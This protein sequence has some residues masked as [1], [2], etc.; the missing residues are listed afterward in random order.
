M[1]ATPASCRIILISGA[2][3]IHECFKEVALSCCAP[4]ELTET[5]SAASASRALAPGGSDLVFIDDDLANEDIVQIVSAAR[6]SNNAPLTLLMT[7]SQ[8]TDAAFETD[9][10]TI[11]PAG[12]DDARRLIEGAIRLRRGMRVLVVD[13]SSTMRSIVRKVL[14][15]TRFP[16][17]IVEVN[18]GAAALDAARGSEFGVVFLDCNMP[19]MSGLDALSA[20][21]RENRAMPVV[22]ITSSQ[23]EALAEKISAQGASL[24]KKPFFPEDVEAALFDLCGFRALNTS[25]H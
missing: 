25:R 11:K 4:V 14:W 20:L 7:K 21:K 1:T 22:M 12:P 17:E 13:D 24:L 18:D 6:G 9:A 8:Q 23:D 16:L 10:I 19:G 2:K 15:A 3:A 5:T